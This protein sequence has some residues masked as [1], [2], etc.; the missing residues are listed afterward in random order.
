M[1]RVTWEAADESNSKRFLACHAHTSPLGRTPHPSRPPSG[2]ANRSNLTAAGH[3]TAPCSMRIDA[4]S[5]NALARDAGC[6]YGRD[7]PEVDVR[8]AAG[9]HNNHHPPGPRQQNGLSRLDT[10]RGAPERIVGDRAARQG[11]VRV[12]CSGAAPTL[13]RPSEGT[14]TDVTAAA[15]SHRGVGTP[16]FDGRPGTGGC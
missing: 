8:K 13:R 15:V 7:A 5:S 1:Q 10:T 3:S 11:E 14:S 9:G 4:S 16:Q 6:P 2:L 12:T